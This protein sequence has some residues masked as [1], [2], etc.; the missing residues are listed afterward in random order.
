MTA[1]HAQT[2]TGFGDGSHWT[3]NNG[4]VPSALSAHF[5]GASK[6]D[7]TVNDTLGGQANSI[8][9]KPQTVDLTHS[10][11]LSFDYQVTSFGNPAESAPADGFTVIFQNQGL[12]AVGAGG[13]GLGYAGVTPSAALSFNV[14]PFVG[15]SGI[16][17]GE[18]FI[19]GG[20]QD[21]NYKLVTVPLSS[22]DLVNF[23]VDY[24][25]TTLTENLTDLTYSMP[26]YTHSYDLSLFGGLSGIVGNNAMFGFTGGDGLGTTTQ[27]LSNLNFQFTP[28][29][30]PEPFTMGLAIAGI[31]MFLRRRMKVRA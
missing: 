25:G 19:Q 5:D 17:P 28:G 20:I 7:L 29:A 16:A 23:Q 9:Y 1:A 11:S 15:G 31:G 21:L 24:V 8:Y 4:G 10:F 22:G 18:E 27:E 26:V 2:I 3:N 13:S 6:V 14:W 30:T 12:H